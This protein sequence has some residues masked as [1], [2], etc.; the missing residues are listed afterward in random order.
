M[1]K[2][3]G[4]PKGAGPKGAAP[5]GNGPRPGP[6]GGVQKGGLKKGG[7]Q[8]G[9]VQKG[10]NLKA[11]LAANRGKPGNGMKGMQRTA[12]PKPKP[13]AAS[14]ASGRHTLLLKQESGAASTRTWSDFGSVNEA[15][16]SFVTSYEAKL[17]NL[18]PGQAT[19]TYSV[20]DLQQYV[21]AMH[22]VSL[23][24]SDPQTKQ[25]VD[26]A[27]TATKKLLARLPLCRR[28][29]LPSY[30]SPLLTCR[31]CA[32]AAAGM[33]PRARRTSSRC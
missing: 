27:R 8:K 14:A 18:N 19:L 28:R 7:V 9:G 30:R 4:G 16:D 21:D 13:A 2:K 12:P 29:L 23:L 5:K 25:S 24:V 22:D 11:K 3:G 6:K 17:R 33:P 1:A 15:I 10:V 20:A 31:A 32:C 26:R